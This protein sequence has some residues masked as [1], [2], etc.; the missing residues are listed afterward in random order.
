[1]QQRRSV[2][3]TLSGMMLALYA[4][5]AWSEVQTTPYLSMYSTPLYLQHQAMPYANPNAPKGGI[6]TLRDSGTFDNLNSMNGKGTFVA[7]VNF[8]FDSLMSRSLDEPGVMYPLLAEKVTL[9]PKQ[10]SSIIFHL[11]PKA[12]FSNG[13]PVTAEDVKFTF[14]TYQSKANYGLQM[15]IADLAKTEVLSQHQV[16]MTFKSSNNTELPSILAE[17]S[18]YSKADWNGKDFGRATMTPILGSGPYMIDRIDAGRSITY[19]RDPNYWAKDLPVNRG[20]YNFDQIKY[21]YYRNLNTAFEGFKTGQY[22]LHEEKYTR[23]WVSGYNFPA[24]KAGMIQKTKI[25]LE[26]PVPT[27]S[28][29]FNM[30]RAPF[31]DIHLRKALSLAYDFEWMNKAMFYGQLQRLNSYFQNS[32]LEAKSTPSA[33]ELKVLQPYL[34]RL[35]PI[36]RQEV[37]LDWKYPASD[38]SGFHRDGLLQARQILLDA[39]Y[40]YQNGQLLDRQSK[41][42]R[43]EFM[44]HQDG[45]QRTLMP[46]VRN[47]KKLG[48]EVNIRLVDVPQYLERIRRYDYDMTSFVMPQS[49]SPGNEQAQMWGSKAADEVGNYNLSGIKNPVIDEVIQNIIRAPNREQLVLQTR[50]LD[51]L[52]RSGYYQLLTYNK[53]DTWIAYWNIYQFPKLTPKLSTGFEF[54]WVDPQ[55]AAKV[56]QYLSRK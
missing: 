56:N 30:R 47:V 13:T 36:Q 14:D 19:K 25:K 53:P 28:F 7:G 26:N 38:G 44:I 43:L 51:R 21:V 48:I 35:E 39:G 29:I 54:W 9:D 45:L 4:S 55:Q 6:M 46:F 34:N 33:A 40:R 22:T 3:N 20:R 37:L 8:L 50:V 5:M 12:R 10:S 42:I 41:P 2:V 49:L 52:L 15:Y 17:L 16:R 11:N 18:I 23:T 31:N 1:M 27:Q 24:V 32:E